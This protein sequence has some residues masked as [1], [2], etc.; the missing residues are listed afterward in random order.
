VRKNFNINKHNFNCFRSSSCSSSI[1][2]LHSSDIGIDLSSDGGVTKQGVCF[3]RLCTC[4]PLPST[5]LSPSPSSNNHHSHHPYLTTAS[6][7]NRHNTHPV[8]SSLQGQPNQ[9]TNHITWR[10]SFY[11][12]NQFF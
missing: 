1:M 9:Q 6:N 11:P 10:L 8:S 3:L 4:S 12:F 7:N 2:I 5:S